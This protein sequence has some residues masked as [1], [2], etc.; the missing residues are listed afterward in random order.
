MKD[1]E[2]MVYKLEFYK[3]FSDILMKKMLIQQQK[4]EELEQI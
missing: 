4:Q 1:L 2:Y 3:D